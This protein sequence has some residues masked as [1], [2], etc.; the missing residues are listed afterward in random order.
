M[1]TKKSRITSKGQVTVPVEIRRALG[2]G[3]GDS[4][5]F[6]QTGNTVRIKAERAADVFERWRGI[7]NHGL[8]KGKTAVLKALREMR[9]G[10]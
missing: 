2:V 3:E 7:G 1:A 4:L 5:I 8:E 9:S 10:E 6:E